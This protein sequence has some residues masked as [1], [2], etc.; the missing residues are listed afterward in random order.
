[1]IAFNQIGINI[2][3]PGQFIEFDAAKAVSGVPAAPNKIL[4]IG[5]RLA[6]GAVAALVPVRIVSADQATNAFGRGSMLDRMARALKQADSETECWAIAL[7]ELGGGTAATGT[8]TITSAATG[9]GTIALMIAGIKVPVAVASGDSVA[10]IGGKIVAAIAADSNL[11]VTAAN[12]AG[13]VTLTERHKGAFGNDLDVRHSYDQDEV[14]P[15]G[16]ALAIVAMTGGAGN[17]DI[18]TALAAIGEGEQYRTIV[19]GFADATNLGLVEAELASRW[20]PMRQIE[21]L[22]YGAVKGSQGTMAGFGA[23]R[24]SPYVSLI[25][26]GKAPGAPYEWAASYAG[27]AGYHG[28]IDPARPLQTLT[29]PGL[30]PP[31]QGDR[32][33]RNERDLLLRDGISTYIVDGGTVRIERAITTYQTNAFGLDDIAWLDLNTPMTIAYLRFAVRSRIAAKFPR[34]KLAND[35]SNFGPGQAVVTPVIIKAELIAL[36][37]EMEQAGLVENLDAFKA[38]LIVE[39]DANDPNRVNAVIP[40]DI[41]NQ[42][43]V[44]AG[45]IEFRL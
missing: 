28:S 31:A 18:A 41:V 24:N 22:A 14:L 36:M 30:L 15:A 29:L 3:T 27:T 35:G 19:L 40:P 17:P 42:L 43:R 12:A 44:F 38:N 37:R 34:H 23:G 1:M 32:L 2:R 21:G 25:G 10:A 5:L 7:N 39:R 33:T 20:G 26:S 8:I 45:R 13:V 11:P 16:V 4:L 9:A 6:A